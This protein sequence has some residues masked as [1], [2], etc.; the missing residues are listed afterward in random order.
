M[1]IRRPKGLE[2]QRALLRGVG[3]LPGRR[4]ALTERGTHALN[5]LLATTSARE[6]GLTANEHGPPARCQ[7][8]VAG[9]KFCGPDARGA[10][11]DS[12]VLRHPPVTA[13]HQISERNRAHMNATEAGHILRCMS[14]MAKTRATGCQFCGAANGLTREHVLAEWVRPL[15]AGPQSALR[16]ANGW[17]DHA[18]LGCA[19][20]QFDSAPRLS[21]MQQRVDARSRNGCKTGSD[22]THQRRCAL[23]HGRGARDP[24]SLGREDCDGVRPDAAEPHRAG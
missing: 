20:C 17:E 14:A 10:T 18:H 6:A 12:L 13:C 22:R 15:L 24:G 3:K 16:P 2:V 7:G 19:H 9:A 21:R 11:T 8:A 23:H 1:G 5:Q 4:R